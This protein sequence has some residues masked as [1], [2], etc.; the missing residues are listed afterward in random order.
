MRTKILAAGAMLIV[1]LGGAPA[2]PAA[3]DAPPT[4]QHAS[5]LPMVTTADGRLKGRVED[6]VDSF[7]GVPFAAP[8]VGPLR[9]HAPEP[10]KPWSGVRDALNF[11]P[12]CA[13]APLGWNDAIAAQSREDCLYL[14]VWTPEHHNG[15]ALPV[16][17][18][19]HGGAYHGGSARGLSAIEPS[20]DGAKLA[21][22][23]VIVVTANYRLGLFGFLAHPD[24]DAES[25]E[26]TSGNYALLDNIAALKWVQAN[27]ARFGGNPKNVTIFG[28]SAGAF[29]VGFLMTSPLAKGLF[30]KA[31]AHSGTVLAHDA[32]RPELKQAEA[33]GVKFVK[34]LGAPSRGAIAA[35]RLR[36]ARDLLQTMIADPKL[37][38][39]EPRDPVVD[40][41]VLPEQPARVFETGREAHVPLIIGN[42]ARDGDLDSMG[43]SGTPKAAATL[44]DR[45][46]PL[47]ET[48]RVAPLTPKQAKTIQAYYA[49]YP[50]LAKKAAKIYG[51]AHA[52]MPVDGDVI[53]AF[54]TD[55]YFRCGASLIAK[56]HARVAPTWRF[57]FTHGY[58]PLGAV[59]LWDML[60]VFGWL[61]P[62]A[63]QP[64]DAKLANEMQRYWTDFAR[65]GVPRANG[66]PVW[67]SVG[68]DGAYMDFSSQG[69]VSKTGLRTAACNLFAQKIV[70]DLAARSAK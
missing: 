41:Y 11:G 62:P 6:G 57:E 40:G 2:L 21:H 50:D 28:Q 48:H 1:V 58:E 31:I 44:A 45:S 42:T 47:A 51:G 8:P 32:V 68:A 69:A 43:V 17:V 46:R 53:T 22:R 36:S 18:F 14:N 59:H 37:H 60:Y 65:T 20:Y 29:S 34:G 38:A 35:L 39:A 16:M 56:W 7:K 10:V 23:G 64:R 52:A 66:L 61:K 12:P 33:A 30:A 63:D 25:P 24:L 70:R 26:H 9:W 67:P 5:D 55:I 3:K 15:R 4:S 19:F 13:Q 27:I 49:H 54:D